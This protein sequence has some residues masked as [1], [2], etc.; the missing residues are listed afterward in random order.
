MA[1]NL[2]TSFFC[3]TFAVAKVI[4]KHTI[5]HTMRYIL[6]KILR[7]GVKLCM[8]TGV[9][10][11]VTACYG[12]RPEPDFYGSDY[13]RDQERLEQQLQSAHQADETADNELKQ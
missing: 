4:Y 7:A 5:Q 1:L 8:L 12:V 13:K 6:E 10:F 2:L 9:T 11:L 3:C